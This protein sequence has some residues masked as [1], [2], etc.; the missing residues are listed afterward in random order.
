VLSIIGAITASPTTN[1]LRF[2][3]H[4]NYCNNMTAASPVN[5]VQEARDCSKYGFIIFRTGYGDEM[6]WK[7]FM[8]YLNAQV[9]ARMQEE[10]MAHEV[11][12]IDW[13]VQASTDL[14]GISFDEVR[15]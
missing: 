10:G 1:F 5:D 9:R 2:R 6:R 13:K 8:N 12:N 3:L 11:P 14:E 4:A 7:R 15:Q